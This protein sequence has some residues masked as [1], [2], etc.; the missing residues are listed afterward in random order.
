MGLSQTDSNTDSAGTH[1]SVTGGKRGMVTDV[2][3]GTYD[4]SK[5]IA[6][7]AYHNSTIGDFS[8]GIIQNDAG[9]ECN[10]LSVGCAVAWIFRNQFQ[11]GRF[12][13]GFVAVPYIQLN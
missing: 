5:G 12:T 6:G 7:K 4:F 8:A 9:E 3:T 13:G 11:S 2:G 1:L 10:I